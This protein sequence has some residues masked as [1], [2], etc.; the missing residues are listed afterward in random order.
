MRL[1]AASVALIVIGCFSGCDSPTTPAPPVPMTRNEFRTD[2]VQYVGLVKTG[3]KTEMDTRFRLAE[4]DSA[5]REGRLVTKIDS[6][7]MATRSA[8]D[9]YAR[10]ATGYQND[11]IGRLT[12]HDAELAKIQGT[13]TTAISTQVA[14]G[15]SAAPGGSGIGQIET[16]ATVGGVKVTF[17]GPATRAEADAIIKA[18]QKNL[19]KEREESFRRMERLDLIRALQNKQS[20]YDRRL[21]DIESELNVTLP[22]LVGR[23][24]AMEVGVDRLG[25]KVDGMYAKMEE[26]AKRCNYTVSYRPP[27][28]PPANY[29][30]IHSCGPYWRVYPN[31]RNRV[32]HVWRC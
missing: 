26:I 4:E 23:L 8:V 20:S 28:P 19:A 15:G 32:L 3:M 5:A 6:D 12:L 7:G 1:Y 14:I 29:S 25:N 24:A 21:S 31:P 10:A 11:I 17:K 18:Q 27:S 22:N 9:A 2:M 30:E 16:V 13:L